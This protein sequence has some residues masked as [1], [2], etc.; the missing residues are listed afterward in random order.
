M[1]TKIGLFLT[2]VSLALISGCSNVKN[3][4]VTADNQEKILEEVKKTKD[5]TGEEVG[6]LQAYMLRRT[7]TGQKLALEPGKTISSQLIE[8]Q[9]QWAAD[10]DRQTKDEAERQKKLQAEEDAHQAEMRKALTLSLVSLTSG[11]SFMGGYAEAKYAFENTSGR[12]IRAFEGEV[13]YRDVL[14]NKL[15]DDQIKVLKPVAAGHQGSQTETLPYMVYGALRQKKLED[16]KT[17]WKP[18]K[19]LFSDGTSMGDPEER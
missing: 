8:E 18:T 2:I 5:L 1:R 7:M 13:E 17:L 11:D 6:L 15:V 9:R 4:K 19:I 10:Q 16:V 14:D 12:N 3:A